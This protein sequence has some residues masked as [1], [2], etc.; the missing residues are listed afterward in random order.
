[1]SESQSAIIKHWQGVID[2]AE[3]HFGGML[4]DYHASSNGQHPF[5]EHLSAIGALIGSAQEMVDK[6]K[7]KNE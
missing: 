5:P 3:K 1:M 4:Q 6:L 7:K 2:R